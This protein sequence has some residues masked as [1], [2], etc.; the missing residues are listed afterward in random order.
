MTA[1]SGLDPGHPG[2]LHH[3]SGV[4]AVHRCTDGGLKL[5]VPR[6][7]ELLFRE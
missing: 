1:L 6:R 3:P 2:D 7:V 4:P 5:V